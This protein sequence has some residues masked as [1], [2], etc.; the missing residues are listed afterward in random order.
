MVGSACGI[1]TQ[2]ADGLKVPVVRDVNRK[3][4]VQLAQDCADLA[5]KAREGNTQ[6]GST[7]PLRG[8]GGFAWL[9]PAGN[10]RLQIKLSDLPR[11]QLPEK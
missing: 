9:R 7:E 2:T 10:D 4:I 11:A 6:M 8:P 5:K 3:G 1:A